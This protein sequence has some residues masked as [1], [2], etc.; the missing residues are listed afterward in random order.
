[1][2]YVRTTEITGQFPAFP[3]LVAISVT[4]GLNCSHP[5]LRQYNV[6]VTFQQFYAKG[7][8]TLPLV[9]D[10]DAFFRSLMFSLVEPTGLPT[11]RSQLTAALKAYEERHWS[12]AEAA[13]QAVMGDVEVSHND[14]VLAGA[15][16]YLGSISQQQGKVTEAE[17]LF[18]RA[19]AIWDATPDPD[20]QMLGLTLQDLGGL[21]IGRNE[22]DRAEPLLKRA[23]AIAE[24]SLGPDHL[25]VRIALQNLMVMYRVANR[26]NDAE[27]VGLR[28]LN[29]IE[30]WTQPDSQVT[31]RRTQR[32]CVR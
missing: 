30:P 16:Y 10:A 31:M 32:F 22:T 12:E 23:L 7:Q 4:S 13:F 6:D 28:A 27:R 3:D 11:L 19:L 18:Q 5:F 9:D 15:L 1:M 8:K 14:A 20:P 29:I 2:K 24:A 25:Q 21:Y 17:P 26:F